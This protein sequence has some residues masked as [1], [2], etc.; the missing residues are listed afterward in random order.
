[1]DKDIEVDQND[2]T[3]KVHLVLSAGGVKCLSYAGAIAALHDGGISFASISGSSAGSL[4]GAI[5]CTKEGHEKIQRAVYDLDLSTLGEGTSWPPF[6]NLVRRPYAK[7]KRSRVAETFR[8]IAGGDPTFEE[9]DKPFA[10]FGVDLRS[11]KIHVYSNEAT[12]KMAVSEALRISTAAP[13]LFPFQEEGE[14]LLM[15]GAVISQSPVW[16]ATTHDDELPILVLRPKKNVASI[17]PQSPLEYMINLIDLGGAS[18]DYYLINE[19]PR[20]RLVEIDCGS[21]QWNEMALADEM[22][23][24]LVASG[25]ASVEGRLKDLKQL[26][27]T[28]PP[29]SPVG[30]DEN[31]ED[32]A[33]RGGRIA[34]KKLLTSLPPKRDQVFI[35]YSHDD[36]EWL[37]KFQ[38]ALKPY[39]R[40]K[41]VKLWDDTEI[42]SGAKWRE[43]IKK[44][45]ASAKVAVLLVTMRFLASDFIHDVELR[46]FLRASET[47]GLRILPVAVGPGAY[48]E[49]PL[50]E[51]QFVNKLD[52]TL[53]DLVKEPAELEREL[54]RICREIKE[55]LNS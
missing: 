38:E 33:E 54:V 28:T 12:P 11:H 23:K 37:Y 51:Y 47:D 36:S 17:G 2:E 43:E 19:M 25:R 31:D 4:I 9:L 41:A 32:E 45:L 30:G 35:S 1:M 34:M 39:T 29:P 52:K 13:F 6:L 53:M 49:T 15:D 26:L 10:T 24:S 40:N 42:P 44:A 3:L 22:K 5:L 48:E 50:I 46:E 20:T 27:Q 21:V 55:A 18:R 7:F 16:L 8:A 14:K